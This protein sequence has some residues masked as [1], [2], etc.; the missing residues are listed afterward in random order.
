MARGWLLAK[1]GMLVH[2]L[3]PCE[4]PGFFSLFYRATKHPGLIELDQLGG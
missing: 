2:V 1:A 4:Y 3:H